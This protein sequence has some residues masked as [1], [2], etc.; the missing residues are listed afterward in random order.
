MTIQGPSNDAITVEGGST[1]GVSTNAQVFVVNSG[2][3]ANL[4]SLAISNGEGQVNSLS[5]GSALGGGIYSNGTLTVTDC[6]FTGNTAGSS[7]LTG[8][9]AGIMLFSGT[10]TVTDC[11]FTSNSSHGGGGGIGMEAGTL[12]VANCCFNNNYCGDHGGAIYCNNDG[13]TATVTNCTFANNTAAAELGGNSEGGAIFENGG[14]LTVTNCTFANNTA[15]RGGGILIDGPLTVVNSLFAANT[16]AGIASDTG[17][18]SPSSSNNLIDD[19]G[20]GAS[21]L[22]LDPNG[23]QNNGGPTQTIALVAGSNAID[24]GTTTGAPTADQ[25]GVSRSDGVDIG[26]FELAITL[27]PATLLAGTLGNAYSQTITASGGAGTTYTFSTSSALDGLTLSTA[28]VLSGNPSAAGTFTITITATDDNQ[29]TGSQQ[30]TLTVNPAIVLSPTGL[31]IGSMDNSYSQTIT[32]TGGAG[33]PYTFTTADPLDG[34]KLSTG[35]TLSGT[36]TAA[37]SFTFTVTA[38]DKLGGTGSQQY[39]VTIHPTI[40]L[41][42]NTTDDTAAV[43]PANSPRTPRATSAFAPPSNSP[44]Q[45]IIAPPSTSLPTWAT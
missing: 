41:T 16:G 21:N 4:N 14:Y 40:V 18:I 15:N 39:T 10:L 43:N 26:A 17:S 27:S 13:G 35:G 25:R 33:S 6:T 29:T 9:G 30:Y 7:S 36:P 2:V 5:G 8:G 28:G 19:S 24:A 34:L 12:I 37:G 20:S 3:T 1:P 38:T 45:I 42:V 23:L 32:A 44:M 31:A 22:G 11:T